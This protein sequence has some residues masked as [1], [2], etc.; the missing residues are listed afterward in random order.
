[1]SIS[2][3]NRNRPMTLNYKLEENPVLRAV[4]SAYKAKQL[5]RRAGG[6]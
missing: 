6:K 1:M 2:P 3:N 4:I 5:L